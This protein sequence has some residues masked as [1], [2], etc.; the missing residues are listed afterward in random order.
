MI[1]LYE[2]VDAG[3]SQFVSAFEIGETLAITAADCARIIEY[4]QEKQ[5]IHIDDFKQGMIRITAAGIDYVE[6]LSGS[7]D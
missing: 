3:V 2:S 5:Y 4:L 7:A 6:S 1:R